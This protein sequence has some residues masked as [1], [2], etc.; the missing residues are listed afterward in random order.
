[1]PTKSSMASWSPE[2]LAAFREKGRVNAM[3]RWGHLSK[4]EWD[5]SHPPK[6]PK[7]SKPRKPTTA[8]PSL[9]HVVG[10]LG[11]T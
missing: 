6:S 10:L 7:T 8:V 1:M 11:K 2:R 4:A 5:A 3:Q 9:E